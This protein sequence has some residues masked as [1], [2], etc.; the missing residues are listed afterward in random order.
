MRNLCP[1]EHEEVRR[2][3]TTVAAAT[4][5]RRLPT[6]SS[7]SRH[8]KRAHLVGVASRCDGF[9]EVEGGFGVHRGFGAVAA[10]E[11]LVLALRRPLAAID[12]GRRSVNRPSTVFRGTGAPFLAA[13]SAT[14]TATKGPET[15]WFAAVSSIDGHTT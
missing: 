6:A 1:A 2:S 5:P 10:A 9:V 13:P 14:R 7:A 3:A 4:H 11:C 12:V 8:A 15:C